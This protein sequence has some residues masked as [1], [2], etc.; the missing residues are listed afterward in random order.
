[1]H[2]RFDDRVALVT[3]AAQGIGRAIAEALAQAGA[4]IHLVDL[5]AEGVTAAARELGAAAHV[6]DLGG[7][8]A[9]Q[10]TA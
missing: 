3:G 6:A 4:R 10:E 2:I 8:A 5:D 9:A 7:P 1:M